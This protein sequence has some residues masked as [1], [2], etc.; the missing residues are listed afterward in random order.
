MAEQERGTAA[1]APEHSGVHVEAR[2]GARIEARGL[3]RRFGNHVALAGLDLR[4]EPGEAFG[5]LGANGAGKTTF[6]RLATGFLLPSA[7]RIEIDGHSAADDPRSAGRRVGFVAE[8][9]RLYPELR[10]RRLLAF[11]AGARG[12]APAAPAAPPAALNATCAAS[13]PG[14]E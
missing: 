12:L 14:F 7:G 4:V 2:T 5:L 13:S 3:T 8:T 9:T 10:V 1:P 11:V 6:L